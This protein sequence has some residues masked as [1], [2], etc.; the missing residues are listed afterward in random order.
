MRFKLSGRQPGTAQWI[1]EIPS[2]SFHKLKR[3]V[4]QSTGLC[5]R[6]GNFSTSRDVTS[7]KASGTWQKTSLPIGLPAEAVL[8]TIPPESADHIRWSASIVLCTTNS[9]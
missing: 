3:L 9:T 2:E 4:T 5:T 7:V 6:S 1:L 8:V